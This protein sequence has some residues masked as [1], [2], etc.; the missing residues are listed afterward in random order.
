MQYVDVKVEELPEEEIKTGQ[1]KFKL[2]S[3]VKGS[4]AA[5]MI[6]DSHTKCKFCKSHFDKLP[7][8]DVISLKKNMIK[9]KVP[10]PPID[11]EEE[12]F[13]MTLIS[14]QMVNKVDNRVIT[15]D[16]KTLYNKAKRENVPF[17]KYNSWLTRRIE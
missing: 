9:G 11:K 14:Y 8:E 16:F 1:S 7:K 13:K 2:F 15:L 17:F 4:V 10:P 6:E 3:S 5:S 12:Y